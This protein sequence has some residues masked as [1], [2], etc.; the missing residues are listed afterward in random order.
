MYRCFL[1]AAAASILLSACSGP[2]FNSANST[3]CH[4]QIDPANSQSFA[5]IVFN[6]PEIDKKSNIPDL[7]DAGYSIEAIDFTNAHGSKTTNMVTI[8]MRK[9]R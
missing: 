2:S 8:T 1:I 6:C 4:A 3:L 7:K 9:V 5:E